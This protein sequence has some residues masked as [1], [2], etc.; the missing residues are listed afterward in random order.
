[1]LLSC[2]VWEVVA[3]SWCY[4]YR[5]VE[6][7]IVGGSAKWILFFK[8]YFYICI[9][10]RIIVSAIISILLTLIWL[11]AKKHDEDL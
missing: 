1:M 8:N 2:L 5:G 9:E 7:S 10:M 11:Q 4:V 6:E 3:L